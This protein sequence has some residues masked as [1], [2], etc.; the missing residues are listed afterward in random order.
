[1]GEVAA[2]QTEIKVL[3]IGQI[4]ITILETKFQKFTHTIAL[5]QTI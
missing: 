1:M 3:T 5:A 2:H 4:D